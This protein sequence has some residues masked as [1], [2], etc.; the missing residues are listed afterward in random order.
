[1]AQPEGIT[2]IWDN[3]GKTV[4]RYTVAFDAAVIE[5]NPGFVGMLSM[6]SNPTHPQG[7]S[8]WTEGAPGRH[9]GRRLKWKD[10]PLNIQAH[11]VARMK[12]E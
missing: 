6:S 8:M 5:A 7:F 3:G 4:D 2:G 12:E 1:M 11:V 10:L 9:L